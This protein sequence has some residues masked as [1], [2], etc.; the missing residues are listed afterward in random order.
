MDIPF[1]KTLRITS[2]DS[3]TLVAEGEWIMQF[4]GN[5]PFGWAEKDRIRLSESQVFGSK[6]GST[7]ISTTRVQVENL[8]TKSVPI[9]LF[10]VGTISANKSFDI[11]SEAQPSIRKN[12]RLDRESIIKAIYPGYIIGVE[13]PEGRLTKWQIDTTTA[14]GCVQWFEGDRVVIEKGISETRFKI[15]NKDRDD[16]SLGA[17]FYSEE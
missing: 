12:I 9:T 11:P 17:V 15:T 5:A 6:R 2:I 13:D 1:G 10:Y 14:T 4:I 3:N 8:E 7:D 16:Q